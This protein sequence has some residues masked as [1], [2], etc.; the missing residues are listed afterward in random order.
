MSAIYSFVKGDTKHA[1]EGTVGMVLF[2]NR[3]A[4]GGAC[5]SFRFDTYTCRHS[6]EQ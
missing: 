5:M 6:P 1:W 2:A 4:Q 3:V